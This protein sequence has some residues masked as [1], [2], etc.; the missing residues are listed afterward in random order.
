MHATT[1]TSAPLIVPHNISTPCSPTWACAATRAADNRL[2]ALRARPCWGECP[3]FL[4]RRCLAAAMSFLCSAYMP[5]L[6]MPSV[7]TIDADCQLDSVSFMLHAFHPFACKE[8]YYIS[9][10]ES[11]RPTGLFS[12]CLSACTEARYAHLMQV[13][14]AHPGQ[15]PG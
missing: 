11:G 7:L 6:T 15:V 14:G 1:L 12:P 8:L 10:H 9:C 13:C 2:F 4:I 5:C 3:S